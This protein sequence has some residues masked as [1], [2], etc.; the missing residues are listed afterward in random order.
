MTSVSFIAHCA[1]AGDI[2]LWNPS[3][4]FACAGACWS[5]CDSCYRTKSCLWTF[6]IR[7]TLEWSPTKGMYSLYCAMTWSTQLVGRI[8]TYTSKKAGLQGAPDCLFPAIRLG[9]RIY[10][11]GTRI[12]PV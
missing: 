8:A 12:D 2:F 4:A 9:D 6:V 3:L 7:C 5:A 10:E 1:L 11:G